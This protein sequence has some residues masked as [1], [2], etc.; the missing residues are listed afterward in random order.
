MRGHS[1]EEK[2]AKS[3]VQPQST[4]EAKDAY[5]LDTDD[6]NPELCNAIERNIRILTARRHREAQN[7]NLQDRLAD[8]ITRFSGSMA[9]VYIHAVLFV[10]WILFNQPFINHK[11]ID[12]FPFNFLT[13]VVSLEAI[14]LS[15]FVLL[16][17]NRMASQAD[18]RAELD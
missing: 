6:D 2:G 14:F 9:F 15:T 18:R 10:G 11:P 1:M 12:P 8:A 3:S 4:G 17:Q 7:R 13:M 16:S 5:E